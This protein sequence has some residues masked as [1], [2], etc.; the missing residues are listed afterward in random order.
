MSSVDFPRNEFTEMIE[1]VSKMN[2]GVRSAPVTAGDLPTVRSAA[3]GEPTVVPAVLSEEERAELDARAIELGILP[4]ADGTPPEAAYATM[5][6]ALAAGAPVNRP[7]NPA[8]KSPV[9]SSAVTPRLPDLTR[10][11]GIDL[12]RGVVYVDDMEFAM[13]IDDTRQFARYVM[14]L[15]RECVMSQ[16]NQA[17][18]TFGMKVSPVVEER[19]DGEEGPVS[20]VQKGERPLGILPIRAKGKKRKINQKTV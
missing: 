3:F 1:R 16:F 15:A 18:A 17:L 4:P 8:A 7:P 12:V 6:E 5:E 10:V 11:Q 19:K 9:V 14:E 20:E 2:Q 13:P